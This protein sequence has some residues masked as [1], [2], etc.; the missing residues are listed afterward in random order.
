[1]AISLDYMG[2]YLIMLISVAIAIGII[3]GFRGQI[4]DALPEL[5]NE[6][7]NS[8]AQLI[9][10][11]GSTSQ[12]T[13]KIADLA[14]LCYEKTYE[15]PGSFTCF[16]VRSK[17]G[18]FSIQAS[19]LENRMSTELEENTVVEANPLNRDSLVIRYGVKQDKVVI[20]Q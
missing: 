3:M 10:V 14:D 9:T 5:D 7:D 20:E 6:D 12:K 16:I 4:Q 11:E 13:G 2:K 19:E 18:S 8:G 17:K 1:M 15:E